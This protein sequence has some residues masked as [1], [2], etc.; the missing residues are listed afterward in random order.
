MLKLLM[1]KSQKDLCFSEECEMVVTVNNITIETKP[2]F[3][4][5]ETK[6][7]DLQSDMGG[8]EVAGESREEE[9]KGWERERVSE[10]GR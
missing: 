4:T 7:N 1:T 6:T 5:L 9:R 8:R 2:S 10:W 3:F